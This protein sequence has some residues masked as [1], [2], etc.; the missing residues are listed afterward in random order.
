[1]WRRQAQNGFAGTATTGTC[2]QGNTDV[3]GLVP[4]CHLQGIEMD[5]K[6]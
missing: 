2:L 5:F 4:G 1:M 6:I 3:N